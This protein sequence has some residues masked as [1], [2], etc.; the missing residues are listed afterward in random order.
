MSCDWNSSRKPRASSALPSRIASP[1]AGAAADVPF[2]SRTNS[3]KLTSQ[4]SARL[5]PRMRAGIGLAAVM[6]ALRSE[7]VDAGKFA[8]DH[9]LVHGLGALVGDDRFEVQ[10]V[11]DR[12]VLGGDAGAAEQV[13][14]LACD[15][16]RHPAVVPLGQRDLLRGHPA[17]V[18]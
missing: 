18:L 16:D 6:V 17:G 7:R 4:I 9:Q 1:G 11:A 12:G 14:A 5:R 10:R 3:W 15:V 8:A 13:A 2:Q